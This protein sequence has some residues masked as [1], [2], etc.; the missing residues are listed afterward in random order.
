LKF[1]SSSKRWRFAN[2]S[3]AAGGGGGLSQIWI[4]AGAFAPTVTNGMIIDSEEYPTNDIQNDQL[5][6]PDGTQRYAQWK[7]WLPDW[8][9]GTFKVR[10]YWDAATGAT[11]TTEGTAWDIEAMVVSN[12]DPIDR[13]WGS[14]VTVTDA[15]LAVGDMHMTPAS[16]AITA[17]GT[18]TQD[19]VLWIRVSRAVGNASDNMTE[20]AKFKGIM[21]QYTKTTVTAW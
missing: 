2:D 14:T 12:D 18:P 11:P 5:L 19:D 8:D 4:D 17:A 6:C 13:T 1:V 20:D 21:I 16:G 9:L 3:T 15:V 10:V 7:G